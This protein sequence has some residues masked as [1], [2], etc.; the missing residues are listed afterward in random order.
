LGF[1]LLEVVGGLLTNSLAISSDS[2]HDLGDSL[3]LGLSWFLDSYSK[4][5]TD[6]HDFMQL[7]LLLLLGL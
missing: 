6:R 7:S 5:K 3:S 4:K 1:A 2:L